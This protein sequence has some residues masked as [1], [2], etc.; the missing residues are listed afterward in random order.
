MRLI[1][2]YAHICSNNYRK[3]SNEFEK[4][5]EGHRKIWR[6]RRG[7]NDINTIPMHEKCEAK[8]KL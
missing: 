8:M 1:N 3:R 7:R 4:E 5:F 6:G 2:I